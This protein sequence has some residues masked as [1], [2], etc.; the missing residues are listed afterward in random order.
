MESFI[1]VGDI[2]EPKNACKAF[3]T[4]LENYGINSNE[5]IEIMNF[6]YLAGGR[7]PVQQGIGE[8][9]FKQK[10]KEDEHTKVLFHIPKTMENPNLGIIESAGAE[11]TG[12]YRVY[13]K[14][15]TEKGLEIASDCYMEELLDREDELTAILNKYSKKLLYLISLGIV[16]TNGIEIDEKIWDEPKLISLNRYIRQEE[17]AKLM[18]IFRYKIKHDWASVR[19][20]PGIL[21]YFEDLRIKNLKKIPKEVYYIGLS[22]FLIFEIASIKHEILKLFEELEKHGFA[23]KVAHYNRKGYIGD[24]HSSPFELVFFINKFSEKPK[25]EYNTLMNLFILSFGICETSKKEFKKY[26]TKL[27]ISEEEIEHLVEFLH[28]NGITSKYNKNTEGLP[29][30]IIDQQKADNFFKFTISEIE[31]SIING[32]EEYEV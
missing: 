6:M 30:F 1:L 5:I 28:M 27:N 31:K 11:G 23:T 10:N 25:K 4:E 21:K 13:Y 16:H 8:Y 17:D 3:R 19:I 14:G 26:T 15:L 24:F 29:F 12:E 9:S 2:M 18:E 22:R 20:N 7:I 32:G